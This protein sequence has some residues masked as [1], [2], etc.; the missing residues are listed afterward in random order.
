MRDPRYIKAYE[1]G[2]AALG[3]DHKMYWR[4]HTALW[5]AQQAAR[6]D[7]DFVECG[8]WRG[9]LSTAIMTYLDWGAMTKRFYLFDTWDGLVDKYLTEGEK[10]NAGK[11]EHLNNHFRGMYDDVR[12]HFAK[13]PRVE[14]IRGPVPD[15]LTTVSIGKIA[16][17]SIDLNCTAPEIAAAHHFW[18]RLVPGA[19][20]LLDDHGFVSYEEQKNAFDNFAREHRTE[21][22]SLP[23]GQGLIIKI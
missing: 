21:V 1:A 6:L 22:L 18:D 10:A 2:H 7:G 15:T 13:F 3:H 11:V 9:F 8:V 17:L 20:L 12:Q 14:M 23:T 5:C 4:L 16:F 19:M